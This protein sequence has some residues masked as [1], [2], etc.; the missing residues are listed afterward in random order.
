MQSSDTY[1]PNQSFG[2]LLQGPSGK[3]KT[4]FAMQFDRPYIFDA[5]NNL[6]GIARKL[7]AAGTKFSYD[8][9]NFDENGKEVPLSPTSQYV[10]GG[11]IVRPAD[12]SNSRYW[13]ML[14]CFGE[15]AAS[16][17]VGTLIGDSSTTIGDYIT[18]ETMRLLP[19]V[20]GAMEIPSWGVYLAVWKKLLIGLRS[21]AKPVIFICHERMEKDETTSAITY[22]VLIPGQISAIIG[23]LFSD[24]WHMEIDRDG[25]H[26]VRTK[27]TNQLNLKCSLDLPTTF[28][29]SNFDLVRAAMA[30][31]V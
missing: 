1:K 4:S 29:A 5:D 27:P 23:S 12:A 14:K 17:N 25:K 9:G 3:G 26:I 6:S 20:T 24:V 18:A 31:G 28:E 8:I 2:L 15:A 11:S 19:T 16:A 10:K 13:R 22:E 30:K 7:K 21:Q